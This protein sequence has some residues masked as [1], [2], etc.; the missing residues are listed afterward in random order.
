[1]KGKEKWELYNGFLYFAVYIAAVFIFSY[2]KVYG[3]SFALL[4]A[5]IV[6]NIAKYIETWIIFKR[7]PLDIK[8]I[9]TLLII[10]VVDFGIVFILR[11][12]QLSLYLWMA[13]GIVVGVGIV[14]LNC[15]ILSLYRKTD[16]KRLLD[17]RV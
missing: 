17:L 5:Q 6:V 1:M 3:L 12:L 11:F 10:L 13:I 2:D 14:I 16:F 15:F 4:F 7:N 8:T 9:F